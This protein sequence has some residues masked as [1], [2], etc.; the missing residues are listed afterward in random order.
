[1]RFNEVS[2]AKRRKF[3]KI[4]ARDF[5]LNRCYTLPIGTRMQS[6]PKSRRRD[7][8]GLFSFTFG[9]VDKNYPI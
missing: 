9:P 8:I 5:P 4:P 2:E 3:G 7:A 1:M 6:N